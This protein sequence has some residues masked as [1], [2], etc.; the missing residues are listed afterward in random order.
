MIYED[1][2][3]LE[4]ILTS[5]EASVLEFKEDG[6]PIYAQETR[7]E[8]EICCFQQ[9]QAGILEYFQIYLNI[10]PIIEINKELDECL[11]SLIHKIKIQDKEFWKLRVEDKFFNRMT[12]VS[13]LI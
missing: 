6:I 5:P 9:I 11:L 12:E 13:D 8:E 1:Y 3:I 10:C 4:T 2:Y 7:T